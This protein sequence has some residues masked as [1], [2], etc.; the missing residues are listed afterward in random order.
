MD[1]AGGGGRNPG[2]IGGGGGRSGNG[3]FLKPETKHDGEESLVSVQEECN[4]DVGGG[5][6]GESGGGDEG[7]GGLGNDNA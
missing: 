5:G 1:L 7:K 3:L 6:D 4:G 2:R